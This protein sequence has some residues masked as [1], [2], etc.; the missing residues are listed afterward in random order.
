MT[1]ETSNNN[2][3]SDSNNLAVLLHV[4]ALF[5]GFIP[6]LIFFLAKKDDEFVYAHA[7]E[8]LN[9]SITYIGLYILCGILTVVVIGALLIPVVSILWIVF[10]I[11]A[12][13]KASKGEMAR[14]PFIV[15][16][17]K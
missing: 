5:F 16:L 11:I 15:R 10:N 7:K 4:L 9:F 14:V 3:K 6:G 12:A 17:I 13:V 2:A 1:Q 8:S